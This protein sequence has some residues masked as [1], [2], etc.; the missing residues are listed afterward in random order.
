MTRK[1]Y[2]PI[3]TDISEYK[4][5]IVGG[6]TVAQR[7]VETL[8]HF[9]EDITVVAPVIT[10]ELREF[11]KQKRIVWVE[12]SYESK[13]DEMLKCADMVLAATDDLRCNE[14]IVKVC[15][16]CGVLV[17]A[18]HKK[19]LCDFY[20]PAIVVKGNAVAGVTASGMNHMQAKCLRKKIND[21]MNKEI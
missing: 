4:I 20:F 14:Q 8:L 3:F 21:I 18:S 16:S 7:R 9:A 10:E 13:M 6:G 5:I 2:F 11:W 15:R 19:E 1:P 17:N 12:K